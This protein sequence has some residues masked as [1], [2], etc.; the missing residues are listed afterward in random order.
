ML[1]RS[2]VNVNAVKP[3]PGTDET[4][5]RFEGPLYTFVTLDANQDIYPRARI[6]FD[7]LLKSLIVDAKNADSK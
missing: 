2:K 1:F 5:Q 3:A 7:D 6:D 4:P